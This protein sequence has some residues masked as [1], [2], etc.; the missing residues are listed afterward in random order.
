VT[1][2][3]IARTRSGTVPLGRRGGAQ[4]EKAADFGAQTFERN[5]RLCH[6]DRGEGGSAGGR[7][8]SALPL[9]TDALQESRT[10]SLIGEAPPSSSSRIRSCAGA[11]TKCHVGRGAGRRAEQRLVRQLA[12]LIT[13]GRW[14]LVE[15]R[16]CYRRARQPRRG[17]H[18][19]GTFAAD[20]TDLVVTNARPFTL[21]STSASAGCACRWAI[22]VERGV[23][24]RRPSITAGHRCWSTARR[25]RCS[26]DARNGRSCLG[27]AET[28]AEPLTK[29]AAAPSA[30][31]AAS[32]GDVIRSTMSIPCDRRQHGD[33]EHR[34]CPRGRNRPRARSCSSAPPADR[35]GRLIR[36]DSEP[37]EV[38]DSEGGDRR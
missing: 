20:A 2:L 19:A 36:L 13:E 15:T 6:G 9:D 35:G 32:L 37:M 25:S 14:D 29:D 23:D 28:L 3:A 5:C 16:R 38:K 31:A 8:A 21:G 12:V 18:G 30:T 27:R 17:R 1:L 24:G 26:A 11:S 10:A 22:E 34:R 33:S 4:L 7:L